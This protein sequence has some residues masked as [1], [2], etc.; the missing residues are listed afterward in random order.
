MD[1]TGYRPGSMNETLEKTEETL[2]DTETEYEG[3]KS[4]KW[5]RKTEYAE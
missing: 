5:E 1:L 4:E 2:Y 3:L